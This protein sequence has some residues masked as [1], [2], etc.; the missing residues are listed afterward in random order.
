M[1]LDDFRSHLIIEWVD[2]AADMLVTHV[3]Y[4]HRPKIR[5]W[6]EEAAI[7]VLNYLPQTMFVYPFFVLNKWDDRTWSRFSTMKSYSELCKMFRSIKCSP[8]TAPDAAYA[9]R[10]EFS[11][12]DAVLFRLMFAGE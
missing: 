8:M 4:R 6:Q 3:R 9:E 12:R 10:L 1:D 7:V 2:N 5:G 11:E